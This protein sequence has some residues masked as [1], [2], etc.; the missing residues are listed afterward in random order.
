MHPLKEFSFF[1]NLSDE[2]F[3]ELGVCRTPIIQS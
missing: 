2:Q 3:I 1:T